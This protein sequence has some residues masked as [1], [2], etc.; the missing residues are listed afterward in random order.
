MTKLFFA[1]LLA[2]LAMPMA[3]SAETVYLIIKSR[4]S[5]KSMV[6]ALLSVPMA[7]TEDCEMEGAKIISSK[8]FDLSYASLDAFECV[9]G[10]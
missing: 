8:R 9:I 6:P 7:S 4:G 3:A 10:K 2:T 1:S 5:G